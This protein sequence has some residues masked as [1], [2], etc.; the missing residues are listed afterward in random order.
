ML[1]FGTEIVILY[2]AKECVRLRSI[3]PAVGY[4]PTLHTGPG[5]GVYAY[6]S[7]LKNVGYTTSCMCYGMHMLQI[8]KVLIF[9]R[10]CC[11]IY[12]DNL[13]NGK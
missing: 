11:Y 8:Y 2:I 6:N 10:L 1:T 5:T 13:H 9:Q 7:F 4:F 3:P 12:S